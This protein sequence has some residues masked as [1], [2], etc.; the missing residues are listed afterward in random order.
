VVIT[1][2]ENT[3]S[4]S[5]AVFEGGLFGPFSDSEIVFGL[6]KTSPVLFMAVESCGDGDD[7]VGFFCLERSF[8]LF[9]KP[10][11]ASPFR[12]EITDGG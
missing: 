5:L 9:Q 6:K 8:N 4:S 2:F 11:T 1:S 10:F 12:M 3:K 7:V